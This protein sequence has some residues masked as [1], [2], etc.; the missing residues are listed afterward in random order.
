MKLWNRREFTNLQD[1]YIWTQAL[2]HYHAVSS[3]NSNINL[4][5]VWLLL[6]NKNH[7]ISKILNFIF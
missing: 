3:T 7:D 1:S 5:L 4:L 2:T 6:R